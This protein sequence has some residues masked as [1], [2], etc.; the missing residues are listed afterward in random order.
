[1]RFLLLFFITGFAFGLAQN[2]GRPKKDSNKHGPKPRYLP[3]SPL[4]AR[5]AYDLNDQMAGLLLASDKPI[6]DNLGSPF[7][8]RAD[9]IDK[10]IDKL[11]EFDAHTAGDRTMLRMLG[12]LVMITRYDKA[13]GSARIGDEALLSFARINGQRLTPEHLVGDENAWTNCRES[14]SEAIHARTVNP[15][16]ALCEVPK[17][18]EA[19]LEQAMRVEEKADQYLTSLKR[20][21]D[22]LSRAR[23]AVPNSGS[24]TGEQGGYGYKDHGYKIGGG[25]SAPLAIYKP[26]PENPEDAG[27]TCSQA[28]VVL[29]II[30]DEKG[31]ATD[32]RVISSRAQLCEDRAVEA[33]R[34]WKF[35]PGMKNGVPVP[36]QTTVEVSFTQAGGR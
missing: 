1:M 11:T 28:A 17:D 36:V 13:L 22:E 32:F 14:I 7:D 6:G 30:V 9:K 15:T 23:L 35:R 20:Q 8:M 21:Q 16:I 25:V 4:I 33:V 18:F 5:L 27:S 26:S 29:F 24:S 12:N 19:V 31:Q 2:S 34:H 3:I 10:E